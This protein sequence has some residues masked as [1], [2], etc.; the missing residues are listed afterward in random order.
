MQLLDTKGRRPDQTPAGLASSTG[1]AEAPPWE[2]RYQGT[3]PTSLEKAPLPGDCHQGVSMGTQNPK[4]KGAR[5]Q[6]ARRVQGAGLQL[7]SGA[8]V[9]PV[10]EM[11]STRGC[12][13]GVGGG[14]HLSRSRSHKT[15]RQRK[16]RPLVSPE[17]PKLTTTNCGA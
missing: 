10:Q 14:R 12:P 3:R 7:G 2:H 13:G 16:G 17:L 9:V 4:V 1:S 6:R 8:P 5:Q 15:S 11:P